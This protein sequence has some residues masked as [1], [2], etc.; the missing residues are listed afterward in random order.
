MLNFGFSGFADEDLEDSGLGT[1]FD[2]FGEDDEDDDYGLGFLGQKKKKPKKKPKKKARPAREAVCKPVKIRQQ[3]QQALEYCA[4]KG[5]GLQV[6]SCKP[7]R[8]RCDVER[9]P[10][11]VV[12][13]PVAPPGEAPAC[14][15]GMVLREGECVPIPVPGMPVPI[16]P[17]EDFEPVPPSI[18]APT[19]TAGAPGP[20]TWQPWVLPPP[21]P[22]APPPTVLP[23]PP[24]ALT[25]APFQPVY[26]SYQPVYPSYQPVYSAQMPYAYG[27][28]LITPIPAEYAGEAD[29]MV[30]LTPMQQAPGFPPSPFVP[31]QMEAGAVSGCEL[32]IGAP[33]TAD[34]YGSLQTER[35]VCAGSGGFGMGPFA[36][37][38]ITQIESEE[39]QTL[40]GLAGFGRYLG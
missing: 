31:E 15:P 25:Y 27:G 20:V 16:F 21:A 38:P 6:I 9:E 2:D 37:R 7:F 28:P 11:A 36:A 30:D 10:S 26:P 3:E 17:E 33:A 34:E 35:V 24:P 14:P 4:G 8:Y 1:F 5:V 22:V 19:V 13:T 40:T 29:Q 32:E 18:Y 39:E 12:P 23:P